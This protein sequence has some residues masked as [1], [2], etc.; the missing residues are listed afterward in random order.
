[1]A[2]HFRIRSKVKMLLKFALAG[3]ILAFLV[4]QAH[5]GVSRIRRE[6]IDWSLVA[7]GMAC[8]LVTV[9]LNFVRW[10]LLIRAL[11]IPIRL[12]QT[13][14]LGALGYA[15]N[16]VSPGAI[17]GDFFRAAFLAHGRPGQ[18]TE[19]VATVIADRIVGLLTIDR[20]SVV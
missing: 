2:T 17:G 5:D 4:V 7:I 1:M 9:V 8:T 15:L 13:M 10:H 11:D 19:S 18:R 14:K 12:R 20:K 3:A 6:T 16:F